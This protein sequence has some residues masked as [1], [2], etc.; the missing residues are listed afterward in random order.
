MC[1][2]VDSKKISS[3]STL[4]P[5]SDPNSCF[6]PLQAEWAGSALTFPSGP[7]RLRANTAPPDFAGRPTCMAVTGLCHSY[8]G[9]VSGFTDRMRGPNRSTGALTRWGHGSGHSMPHMPPGR[10]RPSNIRARIIPLPGGVHND[11]RRYGR[12]ATVALPTVCVPIAAAR[13]CQCLRPE[14]AAFRSRRSLPTKT[15]PRRDAAGM[16]RDHDEGPMRR[17]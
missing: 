4:K 14:T 1:D 12:Q 8:P 13:H 5:K 2:V 16:W 15:A 11:C 3:I 7:F 9:L 17:A 6:Q 10:I